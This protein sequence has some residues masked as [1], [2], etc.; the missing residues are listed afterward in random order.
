M[1]GARL[2]FLIGCCLDFSAAVR[3]YTGSEE[4]DL[5]LG[6]NAQEPFIY[7]RRNAIHAPDVLLPW[8]D[9]FV[10]PK[11]A[12]ALAESAPGETIFELVVRSGKFESKIARRILVPPRVTFDLAE[13]SRLFDH[14]YRPMGAFSAKIRAQLH[15]ELGV[16]PVARGGS[17]GS[18]ETKN[19]DVRA[20][21]H[22]AQNPSQEESRGAVFVL[23]SG[24]T[25]SN[26][27]FYADPVA[28]QVGVCFSTHGVPP[29]AFDPVPHRMQ[30]W[31]E[32]SNSVKAEPVILEVKKARAGTQ[33]YRGWFDHKDTAGAFRNRRGPTINLKKLSVALVPGAVV[34]LEIFSIPPC[35]E[36]TKHHAVAHGLGLLRKFQFARD[37]IDPKEFGISW[38]DGASRFHTD[39]RRLIHGPSEHQQSVCQELLAQRSMAQVTTKRVVKL[40]HAVDRPKQPTF[41]TVEGAQMDGKHVYCPSGR[42][43]SKARSIELRIFPVAIAANAGSESHPKN[44]NSTTHQGTNA[45][46]QDADSGVSDTKNSMQEAWKSYVQSNESREGYLSPNGVLIKNT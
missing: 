33:P 23:D 13:Q 40:V 27:D 6:S 39:L 10:R 38:N 35:S 15:P 20:T 1:F 36:S 19:R 17:W 12:C 18:V 7:Q 25:R 29:K 42:R 4:H 31:P 44:T 11:D 43:K 41:L 5:I 9:R 16:F 30:F 37:G 24:A 32:G 3:R 8:D 2:Q 28:Q 21:K 22:C 46:A 34:D 14:T 26:V 45:V